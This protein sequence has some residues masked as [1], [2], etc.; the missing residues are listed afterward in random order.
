VPARVE[1][2]GQPPRAPSTRTQRSARPS[3]QSGVP[4]KTSPNQGDLF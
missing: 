3:S 1:D 4:A 2:E